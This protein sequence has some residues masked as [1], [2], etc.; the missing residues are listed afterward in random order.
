[1]QILNI[2]GSSFGKDAVMATVVA[3]KKVE[4]LRST[5]FDAIVSQT[6]GVTDQ[7]MTVTWTVTTFG[8]APTRYK[9]ILLTVSWTGKSISFNTIV[10]EI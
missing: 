9:T 7:N 4:E 8:T 6:T 3:Q 2:K 1:M 10:S 5:A